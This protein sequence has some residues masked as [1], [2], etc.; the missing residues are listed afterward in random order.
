MNGSDQ[1]SL[2]SRAGGAEARSRSSSYLGHLAQRRAEA[3]PR[4]HSAWRLRGISPHS[5]L[6]TVQIGKDRREEGEGDRQAEG[7]HASPGQDQTV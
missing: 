6:A 4:S 2:E 5:I 1:E 3:G 7:E